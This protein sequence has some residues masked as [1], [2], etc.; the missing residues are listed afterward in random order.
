[1]PARRRADPDRGRLSRERIVAAAVELADEG[2]L[3]A[4]SMRELARVLGFEVMSLYNHVASREV[5]EAL[6][7]DAVA[8]EIPRPD[9]AL[10]PVP[11]VRALAVATHDVLVTH[12]WSPELW[13]VHLPGPHRVRTMEDLLRLFELSGLPADVAHHGFHAVTN[14][15]L[16]YTIQQLGMARHGDLQAKAAEFVAGLD[17]V[18]HPLVLRHV[19]QHLDGDTAPSFELVLDLILDGLVRRARRP[20]TGA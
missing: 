15:V 10:R 16:G 12:P 8:A 5:L 3:G 20:R 2:G 11:A 9:P 18:A 4:L 6:M 19:Q 13:L 17:P 1:M 7:V 14:H